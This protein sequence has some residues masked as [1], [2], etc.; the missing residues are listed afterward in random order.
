MF[1]TFVAAG[2]AA[3][4][5]ALWIEWRKQG[6][7]IAITGCQL[8]TLNV[9]HLTR[10]LEEHPASESR[11]AL[12]AWCYARSVQTLLDSGVRINDLTHVDIEQ[13]THEDVTHYPSLSTFSFASHRP[14]SDTSTLPEPVEV[15]QRT[16]TQMMAESVRHPDRRSM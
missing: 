4:E 14:H 9:D 2:D 6:S 5:V 11:V 12:Y 1:T 10:A 13:P 16:Q 8:L 7:L 15:S 3:S